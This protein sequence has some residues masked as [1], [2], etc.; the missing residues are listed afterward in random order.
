MVTGHNHFVSDLTIS[1][2]NTFLISSSWDRTMRLWD[3]RHGKCVRQ[4]TGHNKEV[5]TTTFSNDNRQIF[6]GGAD[7]TMYLWNTLAEC[8]MTSSTP[9]HPKP[10]TTPQSVGTEDLRSGPVS[11]RTLPQSRPTI[12][13][14]MLWIS[15]QTDFTLPPVVRTKLLRC[16]STMT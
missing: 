3:L 14:L 8:K 11:S 16:G 12:H 9:P 13:T 7:R 5:M 15:Q 4:F 6:S 2:D 10:T 1:N